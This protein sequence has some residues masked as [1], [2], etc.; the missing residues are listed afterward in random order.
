MLAL[1]LSQLPAA[2]R[3]RVAYVDLG[4]PLSNN[5]FLGTAY[6]EAYGIEHSIER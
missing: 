3:E 4:T 2:C 6:G 5:F 1:V